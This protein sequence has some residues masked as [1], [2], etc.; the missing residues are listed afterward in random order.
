MMANQSLQQAAQDL[1][2]LPL[3]PEV[4]RQ[5][6]RELKKIRRRETKEFEKRLNDRL[7]KAKDGYKAANEAQDA[8]DDE[9]EDLR[10]QEGRISAGDYQAHLEELNARQQRLEQQRNLHRTTLISVGEAMDELEEDP[11]SV[12]D[13]FYTRHHALPKPTKGLSW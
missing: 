8:L 9:Y 2:M 13:D 1:Q 3:G 4:R 11:D 12:I 6:E 7:A 5:R 10:S